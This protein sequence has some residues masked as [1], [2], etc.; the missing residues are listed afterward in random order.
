[1][2]LVCEL[3]SVSPTIFSKIGWQK[4]DGRS[5]I[6]WKAMVVEPLGENDFIIKT[7]DYNEISL[8]Q[9]HKSKNKSSDFRI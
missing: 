5:K 7:T 4:Y 3:S 8:D 9:K 1:M 6:G 2:T